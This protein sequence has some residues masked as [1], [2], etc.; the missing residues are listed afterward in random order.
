MSLMLVV[1]QS[2]CTLRL[3]RRT[4]INSR[5]ALIN[6][7]KFTVRVGRGAPTLPSSNDRNPYH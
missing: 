5:L 2:D 3:E 7:N 4:R 1:V 6:P